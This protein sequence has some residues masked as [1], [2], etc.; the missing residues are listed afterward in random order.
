MAVNVTSETNDSVQVGITLMERF[1][2]CI[3][4]YFQRG[5][6]GK[7]HHDPRKVNVFA[8][9]NDMFGDSY[10]EV[11]KVDNAAELALVKQRLLTQPIFLKVSLKKEKKSGSTR[12]ITK[13]DFIVYLNTS[14]PIIKEQL[15]L[16]LDRCSLLMSEGKNFAL[17]VKVGPALKAWYKT[18]FAQSSGSYSAEGSN[19]CI[20]N[21]RQRFNECYNPLVW[22]GCFPCMLL[23]GPP[24]CIYRAMNSNDFDCPIRAMV[25]YIEGVN[26]AERQQLAQMLVRAY[27]DGMNAVSNVQPPVPPPY[28]EQP[29]PPP[30]SPSV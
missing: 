27:V 12:Y 23:C 4:S 15:G 20:T 25:T 24:Y 2:D 1:M 11:L 19:F 16:Q 30:Y 3:P 14:H 26:Q 28:T 18:R 8:H 29:A 7:L 5:R 10:G 9:S 13:G 6:D 22:I 21:F 17:E